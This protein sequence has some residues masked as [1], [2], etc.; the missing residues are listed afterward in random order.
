MNSPFEHI[1]KSVRLYKANASTF[2][3]YS[4]WLLLTFTAF[5]LLG[6]FPITPSVRFVAFALSVVEVFVSLWVIISLS[7]CARAFLSNQ[8]NEIKNI[9]KVAKSLMQPVLTVALLQ[10]LMLIGGFLLLVIPAFLFAVWFCFAQFA[11]IFE[12]K[13]GMDALQASKDM[14]KGKFWKTFLTVFGGTFILFLTYSVILSVLMS[15]IAFAQ[16]VDLIDMLTGTLP[17]WIQVLESIGEIILLPLLVIF[18]TSV[19]LE[20]KSDGVIK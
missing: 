18:L 1:S 19:Y 15:L 8:T 12:G 11:V 3:G 6:F 20:T 4:S 9:A 5:V 7:I 14:V 10:I 13:R 2:L 17:L 16:G